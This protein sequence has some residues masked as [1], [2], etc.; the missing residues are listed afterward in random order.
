MRQH[1]VGQDFDARF[2]DVRNR[3]ALLN[4][5]N[6]GAALLFVTSD[7]SDAFEHQL[8]FM[9][10]AILKR[11]GRE[12]MQA[13]IY[14]ALKEMVVN[15]TKAN[16]K[17]AWFRDQGL[18][19]DSEAEYKAGIQ[20][21]RGQYDESWLESF[22]GQARQMG[23]QVKIA[24]EHSEAG[25]RFE[26]SNAPLTRFE[27]KR[28]REKFREGM[29]HDDLVSFYM[30][31]AD[32]QEGEGIGLALIVLLLKAEGIDPHLFRVGVRGGQTVARLEIPL[33][34]AFE[35]VRGRNPAGHAA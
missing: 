18:D 25:L 27:E 33:S 24:V 26:V 16:A 1:L 14:T 32:Q 4:Q 34:S 11:Y 10:A 30:S 5:V 23:L 9:V 13:S 21:L 35:S 6:A 28:V 3:D 17:L 12:S 22:G 31:N 20:R 8:D 7:L 29:R 2:E 15:A 19:V